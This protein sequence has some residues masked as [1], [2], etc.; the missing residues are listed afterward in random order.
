MTWP[1]RFFGGALWVFAVACAGAG[2]GGNVMN[3]SNALYLSLLLTGACLDQQEEATEPTNEAASSEEA[4]PLMA[5][6]TDT[7]STVEFYEPLPGVVIASEL[8]TIGTPSKLRQLDVR[9]ALELFD[10]LEIGAPTPELAAAFERAATLVPDHVAEGVGERTD[11]RVDDATPYGLGIDVRFNSYVSVPDTSSTWFYNTHCDDGDWQWCHLNAVGS[12]AKVR[13]DIISGR[14]TV[15]TVRN[16]ARLD[17]DVRRWW[18]WEGLG[19]WNV[20]AGYYRE[21]LF[22]TNL[23]FDYDLDCTASTY[24]GC[25]FFDF[26]CIAAAPKAVFHHAGHGDN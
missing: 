4:K 2:N 11:A 20:R 21:V 14:C 15:A 18:D 16:T 19:A 3:R 25:A 13:E 9:D 5:I 24:T 17:I 1:F 26:A 8:A 23:A 7:G 22:G 12:S 6:A 10:A